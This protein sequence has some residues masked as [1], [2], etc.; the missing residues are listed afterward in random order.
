MSAN[1]SLHT[2]TIHQVHITLDDA[3][4]EQLKPGDEVEVCLSSRAMN[5]T[6]SPIRLSYTTLMRLTRDA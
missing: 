5:R 2:R 6:P 4:I 3:I 1:Q